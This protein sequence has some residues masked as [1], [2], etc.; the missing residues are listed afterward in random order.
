M[1]HEGKT[2]VRF[3][4]AEEYFFTSGVQTGT[5]VHPASYKIVAY[6]PHAGAVETQKPRNTHATI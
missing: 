5:E 6:L 1:G 3:P 4:A 2:G